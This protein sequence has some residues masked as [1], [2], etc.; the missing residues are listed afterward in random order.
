MNPLSNSTHPL[1]QQTARTLTAGVSEPQDK[2]EQIFYYV[3]DEIMF[4]FPPE[5]DFVKASQTIK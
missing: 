1:V 3:R 5:G 2:L 4:G